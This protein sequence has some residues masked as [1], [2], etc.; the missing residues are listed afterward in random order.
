MYRCAGDVHETFRE[1]TKALSIFYLNEL[2]VLVILS[3]CEDAIKKAAILSEMHFRSLRTKLLLQSRNEES[4]RQLE[5]AQKQA[6]QAPIYEQL[7]LPEDLLGLAIGAQGANIQAARRIPGIM[8]VEVDEPSCTFNI[9]GE[10]FYIYA[11]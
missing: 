8:S 9:L 11:F 1:M 7:V 3:S 5:C 6:Q 2:N 10:V 4:I